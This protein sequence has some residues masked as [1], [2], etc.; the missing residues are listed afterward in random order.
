MKKLAILVAILLVPITIGEEKHEVILITGFEPFN[1]WE[2][3]PSALVAM[4]LNGSHIGDATIVSIILP[5]DFNQ[6]FELVRKAIEKYEPSI[7]L[8]LGLNGHAAAIHVEKLA[9]NLKCNEGKCSFI[10]NGKLLQ[11]SSLPVLKICKEL[12]KHGYKAR[13]SFFAGA[14]ACN[15]IFYSTLDY[16]NRQGLQIKCGFI[17]V[18]P[19]KSQKE[20][21]ME[22]QDMINATKIAVMA[23]M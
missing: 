3:N 16:I 1:E 9:I 19:L 20:Y 17:H 15:F 2:E 22:L 8:S 11:I 7:V 6:S 5:V 23:A 21:G 18:P 13:P 10:K 12:R 4:A 14:Y